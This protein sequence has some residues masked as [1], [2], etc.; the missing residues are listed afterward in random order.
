MTAMVPVTVIRGDGIGPEIMDATLKILKAA[1]ARIEPE[2]VSVGLE[3]YEQGISSGVTDAAWESI[4]KNKIILKAPITTP[5]GGGYKSVNV[6]MRKSLGLFANVRP[7][8]TFEPYV[9]SKHKDV[10][11]VIVRE[12]EEDLYA[13]IEYQVSE[14]AFQSIKLLTRGGTERIV[15]YAFEYAKNNGRKK[16]S[17]MVKDNIMKI[18]DGMFHKVFKEVAAEYPEIE[19]DSYIVDIGMAK[20]AA[21]PEI[22]D[23]IVTLNLYGDIVSD[24]ASLV[25]G[26]VGLAGS[27]NIG[28]EY[29]M[30]EAIHGS[31]PDISGKGIAN[32]S[33]LLNGAILMLEH[34]GQHDVAANI[35]NAWV[36]TIEDGC[37]TGDIAKK[38]D[39][40][41]NTEEF[42]Q[43]VIERLGQQPNTLPK[44]IS[45]GKVAMNMTNVCK[46]CEESSTQ[47]MVGV[48]VFVSGKWPVDQLGQLA[49]GSSTDKLSFKLISSRGMKVYPGGGLVAKDSD[50]WRLRYYGQGL[51]NA[52]IYKLL[53]NVD[54]NK[55]HWVKLETLYHYNGERAFSLC[56]GE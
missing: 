30:F 43:A 14:G 12:N 24:I 23:V 45:E 36:K 10:D 55:L 18:G 22:F 6:T 8:Q 50:F 49:E 11:L 34:I 32:P 54:K 48:D 25:A 47:E 42:T 41:L 28:Q 33:G 51:S 17:C 19:S 26:S 53:E 5:Q 3:A 20:V 15:R 2:F 39:K 44:A 35:Y 29:A 40:I 56:Q 13:G 37:H 1:N 9:A 31:A 4:H 16:V 27:M 21:N 38:G 52:D 7:T 46:V